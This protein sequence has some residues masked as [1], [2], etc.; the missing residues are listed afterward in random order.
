M[1]GAALSTGR[2]GPPGDQRAASTGWTEP[3]GALRARISYAS[4]G[5]RRTSRRR[6]LSRLTLDLAE[7][8]GR[9][10]ERYA[11]PSA[12]AAIVLWVGEVAA[13]RLGTERAHR[14]GGALGA[15]QGAH[16]PSLAHQAPNEFGPGR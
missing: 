4:F 3:L 2:S 7:V 14:G 11:Q 10:V 8:R 15:C 16:R 1:T 6:R 12:S 13:D 9:G 5:L